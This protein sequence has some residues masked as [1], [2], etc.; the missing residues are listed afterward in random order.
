LKK[1]VDTKK[2]FATFLKNVG[3]KIL[4][5]T[6]V[7]PSS[8]SP[9]EFEGPSPA[10]S[11]YSARDNSIPEQIQFGAA[12]S[13]VEVADFQF[14]ANSPYPVEAKSIHVLFAARQN[15][16]NSRSRHRQPSGTEVR[17]R[18][19]SKTASCLLTRYTYQ[20]QGPPSK[21]RRLLI[22]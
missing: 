18:N 6:I 7:G 10:R 4:T 15:S 21:P 19:K 11:I 8:R 5:F 22:L 17:L 1:N 9:G 13:Q 16:T 3:E 14:E 20:D 12:R 2:M